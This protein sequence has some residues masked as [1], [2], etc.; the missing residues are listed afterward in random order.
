MSKSGVIKAN[1]PGTAKITITSADK[2]A[3]KAIT[4]QVV[5]KV[6]SVKSFKV[7]SGK[8]LNLRRGKQP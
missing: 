3:K 5:K 7:T 1:R 8:K 6:P 4:I 2:K